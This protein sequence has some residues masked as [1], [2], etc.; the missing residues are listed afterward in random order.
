MKELASRGSIEDNA[1][2]QYV[3]DGINDSS[4]KSILYN[5]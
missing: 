4:A 5:A 1:L 3:I 2:M